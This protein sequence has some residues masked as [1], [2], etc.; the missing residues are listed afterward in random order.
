M[1]RERE[2]GRGEGGEADI[3]NELKRET[4]GEES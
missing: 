2:S 3:Q 1:Y 4:E